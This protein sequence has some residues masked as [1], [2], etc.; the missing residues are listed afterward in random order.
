MARILIAED[1]RASQII[2]VKL[3]QGMGHEVLVSPNGRHALETLM[4][5]NKFEILVTDILMPQ[6]DGRK[7]I[8]IIRQSDEF[9]DLPII[10][11]SAFVGVRDISN[12]LELGAT[13]F[14]P[15]PL[16]KPE[17]SDYLDRCLAIARV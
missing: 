10:I 16:Q 15:K 3:I 8:Q 9:G 11:M 12:L 17:L 7:L 13:F 4:A 5:G 1:D 14:L 2:A 6:M